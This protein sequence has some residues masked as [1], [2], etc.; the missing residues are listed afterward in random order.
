M[1]NKIIAFQN[2]GWS[3]ETSISSRLVQR[4]N[5]Q[6]STGKLSGEAGAIQSGGVTQ[7]IESGGGRANDVHT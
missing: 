5:S 2:M 1:S 7:H 6:S 4:P 3:D